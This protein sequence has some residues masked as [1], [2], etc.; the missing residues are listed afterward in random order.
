M[1][2][3]C[4]LL[5]LL[6]I[7]HLAAELQNTV[8]LR[9]ERDHFPVAHRV[10]ENSSRVTWDFVIS[11]VNLITN[12]YDYMPGSYNSTPVRIQPDNHGGGVYITFHARQTPSSTRRIYYAYIE[13]N[14]LLSN[15]S[16]ISNTNIHEGYAGIDIDPL[17]GDPVVAWHGNFNA[18]NADLEV[19]CSYD[20][21][22]LGWCGLW[23]TPFIMIDDNTP[24]PNA[25]ADE[26]IWPSV[27]IGPSPQ[28]DKRRVYVVAR[29]SY[30]VSNPSENPLIA[31]ADFNVNDF[32]A[33][34][35]LNWSYLTIPLMNNW[36]ASNP[37]WIRPH[38]AVAVSDDGKIALF[39]IADSDGA[40]STTPQ[41]FFCF[42][43][44]NYGMGDFQFYESSCEYPVANPQNQNGTYRF[45]NAN[46]QPA[47]IYMAP[48]FSNHMNG[49][50]ADNGTTLKFSGNMNLLVYPDAWY[51][52]LLLNYPKI[53]TFDL[54][55]Q[56]FSFVDIH[57][58]GANPND[59][60]P[61]IPWDLDEDGLVDEFDPDGYV[62]WVDGWSIYHEDTSIAF[63]ENNY[64]IAKN[65]ANGWLVN[66][67][68]DGC[69]SR[70]GSVPVPGFADWYGYPEIAIAIS[71]N[72]GENWSETL[73][74]NAKVGD[75]NYVA[76]L[77]GMIPVYVYPGDIIEDLGNGHGLV[78][79]FFLDDYDFGSSIHGQGMN[80]GGM[81]KYAAIDIDFSE[82]LIDPNADFTADPTC[83][84]APLSVQFTDT[85]YSSFPITSWEWDFNND[86]VIDSYLQNP[87]HI[88]SEIGVYTVVLTVGNG[89]I[90]NTETKINYITVTNP[91]NAGFSAEPTN[92][93]EPLIV[94]F[95][96]LSTGNITIWEWDFENDGIIDS[97]LQNPEYTYTVPGVFSVF[98][99]VS[100]GTYSDSI[101]LE[102]LIDVLGLAANFEADVTSGYYP[103]E[104]NFTD[105]S[106]GY[107][108]NWEWDFDNDGTID[109]YEQ[110]P[111]YIYTESNVYDVSLTISNDLYTVTELKND[112]INAQEH[113]VCDFEGSPTSGMVPLQVQFTDLSTGSITQWAWDF[114][115]DGIIDSYDPNP[116]CVFPNPGTYSVRLYVFDGTEEDSE[117]KID[118]INATLTDVNDLPLPTETTLRGN[119]PNPFNPITYISLDVKEN[120]TSQFSIHNLKG[121]LILKQT[122]PSGRHRFLWEA[123]GYS[124]GVYF[125]RLKSASY[126]STRKMILLR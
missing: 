111:T 114:T 2:R 72:H 110:N 116:I 4:F 92:G 34:S 33:Q 119:F 87:A 96:D 19:V 80:L 23:K 68:S 27:N 83:G 58:P 82:Y 53:F 56:Q 70:L 13:S 93:Y 43:N 77:D 25:P 73:L 105:L 5:L 30:S 99:N 11:P 79:L 108:L 40:T 31:Y 117:L 45:L 104:V 1:K 95:S 65:E 62:T 42:L 59:N 29:N 48:H 3:T 52:E 121:Q 8:N 21:F 78:H 55:T 76:E 36:H 90:T 10:Y 63:H 49:I 126:E 18:A 41:R 22:H 20:L 38:Y 14:G 39:G 51:Q 103:L 109:S 112:Y 60:N 32:N 91:L 44:S 98:L 101:L 47:D 115:N 24:S 124:S 28:T 113:V 94:Q 6:A 12:Y 69:K 74:M 9:V 16:T 85:S 84:T 15:V 37:E 125:C 7:S 106:A 102:N 97:W 120:E 75:L 88:Y 81:L 50:F 86:G 89:S 61:M 107:I 64:K 54:L 122:F 118:Y 17:T 66:V 100:D 71:A 57:I 26:F 35:N 123:T 67:W 46:Q